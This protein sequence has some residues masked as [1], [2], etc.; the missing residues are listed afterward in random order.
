MVKHFTQRSIVS[1]FPVYQIQSRS[2]VVK[3]LE[4][5]TFIQMIYVFDLFSSAAFNTNS[6]NT[7]SELIGLFRSLLQ[8][9]KH[10]KEDS[11]NEIMTKNKK[12]VLQWFYIT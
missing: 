12:L 4:R 8:E 6:S 9:E 3:E 7:G 1:S 5:R 10:A 11:E 2:Q